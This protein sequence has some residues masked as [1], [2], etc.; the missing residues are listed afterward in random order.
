MLKTNFNTSINEIN[1]NLN[2]KLIL[3]SMNAVSRFATYNV[4]ISVETLF[5][6]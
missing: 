4:V 1:P 2:V 5:L 6:N 3:F